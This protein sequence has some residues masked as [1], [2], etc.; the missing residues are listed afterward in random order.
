MSRGLLTLPDPRARGGSHPLRCHDDRPACSCGKP[1]L[2]DPQ[3]AKHLAP[4]S[5]GVPRTDSQPM[6]PITAYPSSN[7]LGQAA[8]HL[9]LSQ[10]RGSN[11]SGRFAFLGILE[12][13]RPRDMGKPHWAPPCHR[14]QSAYF[15]MF[16]FLRPWTG[17]D[18]LSWGWWG[19]L[20]RC[21]LYICT[22]APRI[23]SRLRFRKL[24][25]ATYSVVDGTCRRTTSISLPSGNGATVRHEHMK[26]GDAVVPS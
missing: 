26:R 2:L 24:T 23:L 16:P 25:A 12:I 13:R 9:H 11:P 4:T 15:Q 21:R 20:R 18:I 5:G 10:M 7:E 1:R 3:R 19:G 6:A 14:C 17:S 22:V 8:R